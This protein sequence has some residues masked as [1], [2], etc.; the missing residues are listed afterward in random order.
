MEFIKSS[1][2]RVVVFIIAS[3]YGFELKE[4]RIK[5]DLEA[6]YYWSLLMKTIYELPVPKVAPITCGQVGCLTLER[7]FK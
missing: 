4:V 7:S 6:H 2:L 1:G 5:L 3:A